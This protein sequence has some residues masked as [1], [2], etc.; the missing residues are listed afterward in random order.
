MVLFKNSQTEP[1]LLAIELFY[2]GMIKCYQESVTTDKRNPFFIELCLMLM[3]VSEREKKS[4]IMV[5]RRRM[6]RPLIRRGYKTYRKFR[7]AVKKLC[8]M[9]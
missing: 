6:F 1:I 9:F 8:G 3:Q 7:K 5:F 4:C 2:T